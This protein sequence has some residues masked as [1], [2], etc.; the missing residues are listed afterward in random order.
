[1]EPK[2]IKEAVQKS[3]SRHNARSLAGLTLRNATGDIDQTS[4]GFQIT[5]DTL[6]FIKKQITEQ[7]YYEVA[8]ADYVP[9][10]VG[11]GAFHQS[12]LTNLTVTASRDFESGIINVGSAN[13]K[14][15][16]ADAAI[17]SKTV[18][19][20]NWA[21]AVG[22]SIFEVE[23]A[24]QSG[25]WDTIEQKHR[26]RARNW[27][28]GIQQIAFLGMTSNNANVPGLLTQSSANV[29]SDTTTL[30]RTISSMSADQFATFVQTVVAA[31]QANCNYTAFPTH[32]VIPQD[33]WLGLSA[34]V[35]AA[36]PFN[37][38][39]EYLKKAFAEIVPGGVKLLP[40]AYSIPTYNASLLGGG[41]GLHRYCMYRFDP[42]TLRMDIPVDYTVTQPNTLNNFQFQDAGYGQFTGVGVYRPLEVLYFD[43]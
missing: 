9:I 25:N 34:P 29:N 30:V 16:S 15:D 7:K 35:S 32:F 2:T 27:Q 17:T 24:L 18:Q 1:M 21:K 20:I 37:S 39:L 43:F 11:E 23:Q 12:I 33:D 36:Y 22:Y 38:K 26:A 41:S 13:E 10:S 19:V 42:E 5:M 14:L 4:L 28:L 3:M 31:Y 8:P 6:T 40:L